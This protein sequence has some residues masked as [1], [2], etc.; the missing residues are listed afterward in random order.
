MDVIVDLLDISTPLPPTAFK[1]VG[2]GGTA[3]ISVPFTYVAT[4]RSGLSTLDVDKLL[5]QPVTMTIAQGG[6]HQ[7]YL[8]GLVIG[9]T[10]TQVDTVGSGLLMYHLG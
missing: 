10:Q 3:T 6:P 9:I 2:I 4:L 1:I 5:H 8:N 7:C